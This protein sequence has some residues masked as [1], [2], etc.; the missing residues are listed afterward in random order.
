MLGFKMWSGTLPLSPFTSQEIT[1][2][3]P[4]ITLLLLGKYGKE[5][6]RRLWLIQEET[7][8][9]DCSLIIQHGQERH[10]LNKPKLFEKSFLTLQRAFSNIYVSDTAGQTRGE[11]MA[12]RSIKESPS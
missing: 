11:Y 1:A 6:R 7:V 9:L 4:V 5:M 3:D 12:K 8:K 10:N 2:T